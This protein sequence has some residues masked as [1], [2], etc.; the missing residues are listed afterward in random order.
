M[1]E[2]AV[3]SSPGFEGIKP[4]ELWNKVPKTSQ[5]FYRSGQK[6]IAF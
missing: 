2:L 5:G 3:F 1:C 4:F 6:R